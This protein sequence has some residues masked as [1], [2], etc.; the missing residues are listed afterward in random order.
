MPVHGSSAW[1]LLVSRP[2]LHFSRNI[3][4]LRW[5]RRLVL[6]RHRSATVWS[7]QSGAVGNPGTAQAL[8]SRTMQPKARLTFQPHVD[9]PVLG[10][11]KPIPSW[12]PNTQFLIPTNSVQCPGVSAHEPRRYVQN[13]RKRA[14]RGLQLLRQRSYCHSSPLFLVLPQLTRWLW[15]YKRLLPQYFHIELQIG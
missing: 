9:D 6:T 5:H 15:R 12:S 11:R 13:R 10:R 7:R 3:S 2:S 4:V 1:T 14:E 8:S